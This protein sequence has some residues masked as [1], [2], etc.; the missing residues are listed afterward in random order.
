M[1][2]GAGETDRFLGSRYELLEPIG[3]GAMGQVWRARLRPEALP[4]TRRARNQPELAAKLLRPDLTNDPDVVR[5]FVQERAMLMGLDHPGIVRVVDMV[6]EGDRLA[7]VMEFMPGGTL[8]DA[9]AQRGT[10]APAVALSA[11]C[12]VLDALAYAH[13]QGVLHRDV[14]P[15]NVL[16]GERGLDAPAAVK[17]SDFGIASFTD[18]Q[19][20]HATGLVGSPAY[21]PPELFTAGTVSAA[22][23]VYATGVMLYELLAGRTPFAG[24]GT[25]H[26]VGFRHVATPPPVLPVDARLW[27]VI[28]AML[29]KD[30]AGRLSAAGAADALRA[31]PAEA[32]PGVALPPQP[33]PDWNTTTAVVSP[34]GTPA[35]SA[36]FGLTNPPASTT[37]GGATHRV[38]IQALDA[39]LDLGQTRLT[40]PAVAEAIQPQAPGKAK[41]VIGAAVDNGTDINSTRLAAVERPRVV[42]IGPAEPVAAAKPKR[43]AWL[44]AVIVAGAVALLGG[45]VLVAAKAGVFS[46]KD[47]STSAT[48][49]NLAPAH[50]TGEPSATGLR[51]DYDAAVGQDAVTV[52]LTLTLTA[53]RSTGLNGDVLVVIPPGGGDACP[54]V[55]DSDLQS[56][57]LSGDGVSQECAYKFTATLVAAQVT[58][59]ALQVSGD[60]G[61]DLGNWLNSIVNQTRQALSGVTGPGFA[62]QRVT[63]I[64][65][66]ADSVV[67]TES[68]PQVPYRVFAQ[69]QGGQQELFRNDTLAF[70]ATN[71]LKVLTG[72]QGLDGVKV[73]TCPEAQVRGTTVLAQQ[74]ATTCFIEVTI[75]DLISRQAMFSI[76]TSGS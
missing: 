17:L 37:T 51:I 5:R 60:V 13:R 63:G 58:T 25:A 71:L 69:W 12:T 22:S 18:E 6:A 46:P 62:L 73:A 70:Q 55:A 15:A 27:R 1:I 20:V 74:A 53:P 38:P 45:G 11:V 9:L 48:P 54:A 35:T 16:L 32:V 21:M 52:G 47:F 76:R 7:I 28:E 56:A 33:E 30:P 65:V 19:G 31:L 2:D 3:A 14:K 49:L 42:D 26:T 67:R 40:S 59:L 64:N 34:F 50:L 57:T 43:P 39:S 61:D 44:I 4:P 36:D 8:A 75:G 29:A 66:E 10:L 23:D 68:S 41:A 72:G 24:S